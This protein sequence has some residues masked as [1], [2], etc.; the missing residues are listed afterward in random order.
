[1]SEV[2]QA[3]NSVMVVSPALPKQDARYVCVWSGVQLENLRGE[4]VCF[5]CVSENRTNFATI[6]PII[7]KSLLS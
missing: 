6:I 2:L 5:V 7:P 3:A 4:N 1:M